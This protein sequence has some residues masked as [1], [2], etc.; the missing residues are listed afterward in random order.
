MGFSWLERKLMLQLEQEFFIWF[1]GNTMFLRGQRNLVGPHTILHILDGRDYPVVQPSVISDPAISPI[2]IFNRSWATDDGF[3]HFC[4]TFTIE[5]RTIRRTK[6]SVCGN[7][8]ES[9]IILQ[10]NDTGQLPGAWYDL[11]LYPVTANR[12]LGV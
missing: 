2:G 3:L 7:R 5:Y 6:R 11:F 10:K 9:T 8:L 1:E 12:V 4:T